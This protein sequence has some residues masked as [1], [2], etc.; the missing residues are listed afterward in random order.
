[1]SGFYC[2][3]FEHAFVCWT[4]FPKQFHLDGT[5][6]LFQWLCKVTMPRWKN[7][8]IAQKE[9]QK[10]KFKG[11]KQIKEDNMFILFAYYYPYHFNWSTVSIKYF[12]FEYL[13]IDRLHNNLCL[14]Y[15]SKSIISLK[16]YRSTTSNFT[17]RGRFLGTRALE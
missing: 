7:W 8:Y 2:V 11:F 12:N 6:L 15:F 1:M 13:V 9:S 16:C 3:N 14:C 17:R 4:F 10:S 5:T